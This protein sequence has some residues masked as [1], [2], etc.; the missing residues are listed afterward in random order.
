[1]AYH[2]LTIARFMYQRK[3]SRILLA[4]SVVRDISC[5]R[6]TT[7]TQENLRDTDRLRGSNVKAQFPYPASGFFILAC[8]RVHRNLQIYIRE[9]TLRGA[10][11]SSRC[12]SLRIRYDFAR[13]WRIDPMGISNGAISKDV[14]PEQI[15]DWGT[16]FYD[17]WDRR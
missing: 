9:L 6:V 10:L 11:S 7:R 13:T 2:N 15:N 8:T 4:L 1:M 5:N 3:I 14:K 12:C 17:M 16:I